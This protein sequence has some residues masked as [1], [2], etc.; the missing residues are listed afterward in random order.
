[1]K[2]RKL[3]YI[4]AEKTATFSQSLYLIKSDIIFSEQNQYP[5]F[6]LKCSKIKSYHIRV[7]IMLA[8]IKNLLCLVTILSS[9]FSY[10][11]Q[12]LYIFFFTFNNVFFN[13]SILLIVYD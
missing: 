13:V 8:S 12:C 1:M 3:T 7:L 6:R 4:V 5:I 2:I 9:L 11:S 10:N